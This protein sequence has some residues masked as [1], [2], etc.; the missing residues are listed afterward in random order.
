MGQIHVILSEHGDQLETQCLFA[1]QGQ[2]VQEEAIDTSDGHSPQSRQYKQ[3]QVHTN[4]NT[5]T[6]RHKYKYR[7]IHSQKSFKCFFDIWV[8]LLTLRHCIGLS[9]NQSIGWTFYDALR[10]PNY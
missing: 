3:I 6:H 9:E 1:E 4:T 2:E 5:N 10:T 8:F 7:Q